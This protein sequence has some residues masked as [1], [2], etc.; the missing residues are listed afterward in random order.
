MYLQ[1]VKGFL[2]DNPNS[3]SLL[4]QAV[5]M[6]IK[7]HFGRYDEFTQTITQ[8]PMACVMERE[9]AGWNLSGFV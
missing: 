5:V 6:W 8:I 9:L 4:V 2:F 3:R 1:I 7:P